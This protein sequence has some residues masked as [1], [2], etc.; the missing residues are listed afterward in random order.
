[1]ISQVGEAERGDSRA[2]P[3]IEATGISVGSRSFACV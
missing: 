2:V 1:M 3:Q